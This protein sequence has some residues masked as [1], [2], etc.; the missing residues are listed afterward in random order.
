MIITLL[1]KQIGRGNIVLLGVRA[2]RRNIQP[3]WS[4]YQD[5]YITGRTINH[6]STFQHFYT[7]R[8]I[9]AIFEHEGNAVK[10][11]HKDGM[12]ILIPNKLNR[13]LNILTSFFFN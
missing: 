13:L 6:N 4:K 5:G 9:R 11:L 10:L 8:E 12:F 7:I 1:R 3:Y 2:D